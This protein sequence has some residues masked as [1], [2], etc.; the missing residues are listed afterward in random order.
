MLDEESKQRV[1]EL[2]DQIAKEQNPERFAKLV[3]QLNE[4]FDSADLPGAEKRDNEKS[5]SGKKA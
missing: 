2:C 5:T 3:Q 1:R 4:A